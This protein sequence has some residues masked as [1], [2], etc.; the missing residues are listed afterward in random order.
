MFDIIFKPIKSINNEK[1]KRS[2]AKTYGKL[3][4]AAII[5]GIAAFVVAMKITGNWGISLL[6]LLGFAA[7]SFVG[8]LFNAWVYNIAI[9]TISGKGKCI[10]SLA[11]L[12]NANIVMSVGLIIA[13][14]LWLIPLF[15]M[16]L[17]MLVLIVMTVLSY[18]VLVR[19][20]TVFTGADL[21]NVIVGIAVMAVA[22]LVAA[23]LIIVLTTTYTSIINPTLL[24][25]ST[26]LATA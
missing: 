23:Y 7:L 26:G 15:G 22:S 5:L 20:L 6:T 17:A 9:S 12:A 25:G 16:I 11:S 1:K 4:V 10:D 3:V 19:S 24:S 18:A 21:L 14:L 2:T 13:V 8:N